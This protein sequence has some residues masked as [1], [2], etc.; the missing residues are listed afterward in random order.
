MM[1]RALIPITTIAA[2]LG[3]TTPGLT[4]EATA[5]KATSI[6]QGE[7]QLTDE[8]LTSLAQQ[9]AISTL[10]SLETPETATILA[11]AAGSD[12]F[13]DSFRP[14]DDI[15]QLLEDLTP[16]VDTRTP[17]PTPGSTFG[18]PTG[19]GANWRQ[20]FVGTSG[21]IDFEGPGRTDG[22]F[23]LGAGFGNSSTSL[24]LEVSM[25]VTSVSPDDFG[26]SGS[27]GFKVHK[28]VPNT[29]GLGLAVGWSNALDW[30]DT[31]DAPES[32]YGV[33][34]KTFTLR[35]NAS[36]RLPLSVSLG[37]GSGSFRS[38][39]AIASGNNDPNLFGSIGVLL[40]PQ[41]SLATSWTGSQLNLG[42]GLAPFTVPLTFSLGFTDVT[43]NTVNGSGFNMNAG[44]SIKF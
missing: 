11:Q 44:Y 24:G 2:L 39:G 34:S 36:N 18:T 27:F 26:D 33:A 41:V 15:Q 7:Q 6:L 23:S 28:I 1:Q 29:N 42:M 37:M 30:G 21:I 19:F 9:A 12:Q 10:L 25:S 38:T 16:L 31:Q 8:A 35:P 20:A 14:S 3:A 40:A 43:D 32:I 17:R 22:S 5:P 13:G 4:A